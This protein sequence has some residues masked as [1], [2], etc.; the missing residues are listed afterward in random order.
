MVLVGEVSSS[1]IQLVRV[2]REYVSEIHVKHSCFID[3]DESLSFWTEA[4]RFGVPSL[5]KLSGFFPDFHRGEVMG[6]TTISQNFSSLPVNDLF[7]R[8]T[9]RDSY[10]ATSPLPSGILSLSPLC[11]SLRLQIV[12]ES[13]NF[14]T[15]FTHNFSRMNPSLRQI[16]VD[17]EF[18]DENEDKEVDEDGV[19]GRPQFHRAVKL[20]ENILKS[21]LALALL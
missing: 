7:L 5:R 16:Y 1:S 13:C 9:C 12:Y 10:P 14:S 21:F 18:P 2:L 4:A 3:L 19:P 17:V 8:T 20:V 6:K 11:S 15:E